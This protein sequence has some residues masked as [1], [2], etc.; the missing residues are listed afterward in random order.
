MEFSSSSEA[1]QEIQE[2]GAGGSQ[3][4]YLDGGLTLYGGFNDTCVRGTTVL[5]LS[6]GPSRLLL[7]FGEKCPTSLKDE[8]G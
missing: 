5:L 7:F 6:S 2:R 4:R 8:Q 1:F 3:C